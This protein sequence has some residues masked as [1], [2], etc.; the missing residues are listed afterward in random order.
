MNNNTD[1][2]KTILSQMGGTGR[3]MAVM[4]AK[5]FVAHADGVAFRFP[6]KTGANHV[7]VKLTGRDDYDVTFVRIVGS[8]VKIVADIK[9][10]YAEQL[11]SV[12][13]TN[14]GLYLSL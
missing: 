8:K 9:G 7:T 4:G 5:Q 6:N 11:K 2:A 1:I 3:I 10:I 13:E 12:F 14:T